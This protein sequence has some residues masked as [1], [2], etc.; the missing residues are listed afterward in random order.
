MPPSTWLACVFAS[1]R[2][3][4]MHGLDLA[5]TYFLCIVGA[6]GFSA[7][8]PALQVDLKADTAQAASLVTVATISSAAGKL[9]FSGWLVDSCGARFALS[10]SLVAMSISAVALSNAD[11]FL[12][13]Q[14]FAAITDFFLTVAWPAHVQLVRK[15]SKT[16]ARE[17]SALWMLGIASR[18][19]AIFAQVAFGIAEGWFGWRSA[20]LG[21]GVVAALAAWL[22]SPCYQ[23]TRKRTA[24][25]AAVPTENHDVDA[26]APS[27]EEPREHGSPVSPF[28]AVYTTLG[29]MARDRLFWLTAFGN[30]LLGAV[31]ITSQMLVAVYLRDQAEDGLVS[32]SLAI[33]LAASFSLGVGVSVLVSGR[34]F[35]RASTSRKVSL[36]TCLNTVST[37]AF[38]IAAADSYYVSATTLRIW[39]RA[40]L[41]FVGGWGIGL[42]FYL[43]PGLFAIHFGG[44]DAGVVSAYLD[45]I[46]YLGAAAASL[47]IRAVASSTAGWP[48]VWSFCALMY[49][50]GGLCTSA[51]LRKLFATHSK[52]RVAE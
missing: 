32:I 20:Q 28:H 15:T 35:A 17:S 2:M 29:R 46:G 5:I 18:G 48:G 7:L 23:R 51:Y 1:G 45:G 41:F 22:A 4:T 36:V 50:I 30:T 33:Q 43:P 16:F 9:L 27:H 3:L 52:T 38:A 14:V 10:S 49:L 25:L 26:G 31:K 8:L 40:T 12:Q 6:S 39:A 13:V 19:G 37:I 42:S 11:T 47:V 24:D 34:I 44:S 21:S